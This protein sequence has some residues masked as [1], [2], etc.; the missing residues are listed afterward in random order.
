MG[1]RNAF[2]P[3][4]KPYQNNLRRYYL[5]YLSLYPI[6]LILMR[7][8]ETINPI[9]TYTDIVLLS[10]C[11]IELTHSSIHRSRDRYGLEI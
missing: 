1:T 4:A 11:N 6:C 8:Y 3:N 7:V 2:S 10:T 5:I 9:G